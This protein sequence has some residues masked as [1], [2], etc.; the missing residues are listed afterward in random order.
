MKHILFLVTTI[1]LLSGCSQKKATTE[2]NQFGDSDIDSLKTQRNVVVNQINEL[3]E[4]LIEINR[5]IEIKDKN[6]RLPLISA[7]SVETSEFTHAIEVQGD[8]KTRQSLELYPE[9]AGKLLS[10]RVREGQRVVKGDILATI[11]DGGLRPQLNSAKL[12][13]DLASTTYERTQRLWN[14]KIG[15]ELN[16]LQAKTQYESQKQIVDQLENQLSKTKIIAPFSGVIDELITNEGAYVAPGMNPILRLINLNSMYV[17]ADI[18]ETY[19]PSVKPGSPAV[20]QI[21]VIES[22]INTTLRQTGDFI[23]PNNRTFRVEAPVE[24]SS[25]LIKPNLTAKLIV[26][27]YQNHQALSIPLRL[28]Q[29]DAQGQAYVHR[30]VSTEE[31]NV[32]ITQRVFIELGIRS[33]DFSEVLGGLNSGDLLVD[34]GS[35][36]VEDQQKVQL[37]NS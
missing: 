37:L 20:V 29:E 4:Q 26:T 1:I 9:F 11:D 15:S 25:G 7:F 31:Q 12:Q 3:N 6:Q 14:Q 28:I 18:P 34:E 10:I 35:A 36:L 13:L 33:G 5:L 22:Q 27:D 19:L 32:F 17:E 21:D 16:Y 30:L 23:N 8:I 24:N 2:Q